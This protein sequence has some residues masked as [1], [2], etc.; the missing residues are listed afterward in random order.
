MRIS[1]ICESGV[2][3][4]VGMVRVGRL[5]R[6][7]FGGSLLGCYRSSGPMVEMSEYYIQVDII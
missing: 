2:L 6:A 5:L 1:S 4:M 3:D 7:G